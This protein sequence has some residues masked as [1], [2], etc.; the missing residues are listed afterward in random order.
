M[1]DMLIKHLIFAAYCSVVFPFKPESQST[2]ISL[3][4]LSVV[5]KFLGQMAFVVRF[6]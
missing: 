4:F 6:F 3:V 1:G 2:Y 5:L